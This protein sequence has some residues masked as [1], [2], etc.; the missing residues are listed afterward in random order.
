MQLDPLDNVKYFPLLV[1]QDASFLLVST[2]RVF[3]Q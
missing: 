1:Q 3:G 2:N